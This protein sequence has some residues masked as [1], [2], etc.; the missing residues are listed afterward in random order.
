MNFPQKRQ[1]LVEQ[2][3]KPHIHDEKIVN[4]FLQIPREEFIPDE[5][6][7]EAYEDKALPIGESQTISQPSLV[8]LMTKLLDLKGTEKVLEI[9]TGSGYQTAILSKLCRQVFTVEIVPTLYEKA[10]ETLQRLDLSN[11]KCIL[12]NGSVGLKKFAPY[13]GIIVTAG[14]KQIP[15]ALTDQLMEGGRIVIPVGETPYNQKLILGVKKNGKIETQ[16]IES[17][18]FVPLKGQYGW[19]EN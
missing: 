2:F 12:G 4:A 9:G 16:D 19:D 1:I 14:G 6:K 17:V 10:T 3:I 11:V 13:N 7:I 8:A 5:Y 18:A 15:E